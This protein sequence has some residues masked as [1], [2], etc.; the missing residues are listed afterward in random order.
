M[1]YHNNPR[2]AF[3]PP[4]EWGAIRA[5]WEVL[6]DAGYTCEGGP[7]HNRHEFLQIGELLD[8]LRED[9]REN[10]CHEVIDRYI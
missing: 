7:L 3:P 10:Q 1:P 5:A 4:A 8:D 2:P 9:L 6:K